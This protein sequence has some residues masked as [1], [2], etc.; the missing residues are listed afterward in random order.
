MNLLCAPK[1]TPAVSLKQ[2]FLRT[3]KGRRKRGW[4]K[5]VWKGTVQV[6]VNNMQ[7]DWGTL[8]WMTVD[9]EKWRKFVAA[10]QDATRS[11]AQRLLGAH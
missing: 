5:T 1:G 8:Q 2:P 6:E 11:S 3:P 4:A 10:L 9:H 7:H